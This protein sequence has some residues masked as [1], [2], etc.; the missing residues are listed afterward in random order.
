MILIIILLRA[1]SNSRANKV[2]EITANIQDNS[3]LLADEKN[4]IRSY[5]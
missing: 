2:I 3:S 5:Q 4:H 1:F